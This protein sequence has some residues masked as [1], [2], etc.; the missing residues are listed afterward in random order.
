MWNQ[1]SKK[2]GKCKIRALLPDPEG[3]VMGNETFFLPLHRH[4]SWS[5]AEVILPS[6]L[7]FHGFTTS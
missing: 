1:S 4:N 6:H 7:S 5:V 2:M 3:K